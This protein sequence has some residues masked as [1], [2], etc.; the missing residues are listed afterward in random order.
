MLRYVWTSFRK[1]SKGG[2]RIEARAFP[3]YALE[4]INMLNIRKSRIELLKR[5]KP[6]T[7][8]I[9][10]ALGPDCR[11]LSRRWP[12]YPRYFIYQLCCYVLGIKFGSD[13]AK[14]YELEGQKIRIFDKDDN[15]V[16]EGGIGE[17]QA[18]LRKAKWPNYPWS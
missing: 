7:K 8:P 17:L 1:E 9:M 10:T 16:L 3:Y 6:L 12:A 14:R 11:H 5:R 4:V 15:V 13:G 18:K 2:G